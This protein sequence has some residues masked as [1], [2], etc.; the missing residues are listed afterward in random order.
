MAA[1]TEWFPLSPSAFVDQRSQ[2]RRDDRGGLVRYGV[3]AYRGV[4]QRRNENGKREIERCPHAH[5]KPSAARKCAEQAARR[6]NR[7][8][9]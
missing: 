7:A 3:R 5:S 8:A 2:L 4:V 6:W 9:R 1:A